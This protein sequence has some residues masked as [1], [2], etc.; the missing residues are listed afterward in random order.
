MRTLTTQ[1][2]RKEMRADVDRIIRR[3]AELF[4]EPKP[5]PMAAIAEALG[6][7]ALY[8]D[9]PVGVGDAVN[10]VVL[11]GSAPKTMPS[12]YTSSESEFWEF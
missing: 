11:E 1:D 4:V 5:T 12:G 7:I 9:D 6:E 3:A 10:S 2:I 8:V